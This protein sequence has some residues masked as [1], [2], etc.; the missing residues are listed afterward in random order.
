M[1][2]DGFKYWTKE[3][4]SRRP[5]TAE[6]RIVA[7]A[8]VVLEAGGGGPMTSADILRAAVKRRLLKRAE[9]N[10]LR[11]RLS[12]H[13][14]LV[15]ARIIRATGSKVGVRGART[16]AWVLREHGGVQ[17]RVSGRK[18]RIEPRRRVAAL[19]LLP[20]DVLARVS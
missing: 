20:V 11:A 3:A 12:Q 10:T 2:Y 6:H 14:D 8:I 17:V 4:K 18:V 15:D 7:A 1:S 13:C 19:R 5:V 16:T 9:Y